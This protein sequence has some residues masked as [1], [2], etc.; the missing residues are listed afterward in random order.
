MPGDDAQARTVRL[1]TSFQSQ[2]SEIDAFL[3]LAA[4]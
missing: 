2:P 4:G 3:A 1:V